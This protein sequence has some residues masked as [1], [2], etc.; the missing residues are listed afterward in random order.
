[1]K[2]VILVTEDVTVDVEHREWQGIETKYWLIHTLNCSCIPNFNFV[3]F[4]VPSNR[5]DITHPLTN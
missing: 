2:D 1:M 3:Y 4:V 5:I